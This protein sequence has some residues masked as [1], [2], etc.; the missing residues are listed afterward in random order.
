MLDRERMIREV[1]D[2]QHKHDDDPTAGHRYEDDL[3]TRSV[4]PVILRNRQLSWFLG[5]VQS[6]MVV[7]VDQTQELRNL[8]NYTVDRYYDR[9]AE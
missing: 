3:L 4:T 1:Y 6:M 8:F 5:Y 2:L 7:M 9:H